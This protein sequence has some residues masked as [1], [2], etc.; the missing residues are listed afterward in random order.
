M[1]IEDFS[2]IRQIICIH[3]S[4]L[5]IVR[6]NTFLM[7]VIGQKKVKSWG[8]AFKINTT[9]N[10]TKVIYLQLTYISESS[11]QNSVCTEPYLWTLQP[12]LGLR[13]CEDTLLPCLSGSIIKALT[14]RYIHKGMGEF[15]FF[16][17]TCDK[18]TPEENMGILSGDMPN[19]MSV[20]KVL[21]AHFLLQSTANAVEEH[22][23]RY[24]GDKFKCD[25]LR[26]SDK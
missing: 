25:I 22:S 21:T 3:Y 20:V 13:F 2:D 10:L 18:T 6:L 19:P 24:E 23:W 11:F 1:W 4:G 12:K 16:Q 5:W 26:L 8:Y 9:N 17:V 15:S 14:N 7:H